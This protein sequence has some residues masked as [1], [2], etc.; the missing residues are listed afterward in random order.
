MIR[1]VLMLALALSWNVLGMAVENANY[2]QGMTFSGDCPSCTMPS[3]KSAFKVVTSEEL[4][5]MLDSKIRGLLVIDARTPKEY[6]KAHIKGAINIPLKSLKKNAALLDAAKDAK[7]I[8]YCNGIKCGKS[9]KAAKIAIE[10]GYKDVSVYVDGIPVWIE[11]G[12]PL[13]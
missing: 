4:K 11:K 1:F 8:F 3:G 6:R 13:N 12:L 10:R 5:A 9:S 7:L 2:A